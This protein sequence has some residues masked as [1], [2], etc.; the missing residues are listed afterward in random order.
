MII[1]SWDVGVVHLAYCVLKFNPG[2]T[3]K[4]RIE[5][6]DWDKINLMERETKNVCMGKLKSKNGKITLCRRSASYH[7]NI[8]EENIGFC[9]VHFNQSKN[10]WSVEDTKNLFEQTNV[11]SPCSYLRK[12]G[13]NCN[14]KSKFLFKNTNQYYCSA[15]YKIMFN[16]K[17]KEFSPQ[18]IKKRVVKRYPTIELQ[19]TLIR[20]LDSLMEHFSKLGVT[21]VIIENQPSI[22]NPK[23]KA[24]AST[25]FDYF[26]IR[27]YVDRMCSI[28]LV[29]FVCPGNKLKFDKNGRFDLI[30][31]SR[32]TGKKYRLTKKLGVLYTKMLLKKEP[33]QLAYLDLFRKQDDLCDSYLQGRYYLEF[34][35]NR[36]K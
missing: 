21:E 8:G 35:W 14:K 12:D 4:S 3:K 20:E 23:M 24:I 34:M 6:L 18:P 5:I 33:E 31:N 19:L 2:G 11:N 32:G 28:E 26:M 10:Y 16:K 30:L 22:K 15:H 27:G 13:T 7:L 1:I 29:R 17:V 9:R 25:L 36:E